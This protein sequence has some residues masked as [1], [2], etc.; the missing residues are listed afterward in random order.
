MQTNVTFKKIDP[1]DSLKNY[2]Q[3]KLNRF[4]KMLESPAEANVVLSVEKIRHIAEIS[5]VCDK[6]KIHAKEASENMYS[7]I[8]AVM[9]KIKT[10]I[11]KNKEKHKK[12]MSGKK[13]SIKTEKISFAGNSSRKA[14]SLE[15]ADEI[16]TE[17]I[18]TKPM[19]IDDAVAALN[20][21]KESFFVFNNAR[22]ENLNVLY[23]RNN[24]EI[25]LIQPKG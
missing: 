1:S 15:T 12:H 18:D 7:S 4:D 14:A 22:T 20:S 21:G 5:I 9:D 25:G 13:D 19:D 17:T 3:K 16:I 24:G 10:Q 23:R 2:V 6:M 11:T 8:D